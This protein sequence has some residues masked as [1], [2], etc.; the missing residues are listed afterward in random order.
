LPNNVKNILKMTKTVRRFYTCLKNTRTSTRDVK[1]V[2]H[3]EQ[4]K[5]AKHNLKITVAEYK[6][7]KTKVFKDTKTNNTKQNN[8]EISKHDRQ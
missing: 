1:H 4:I 8:V 5:H 6:K 7:R 3:V 2:K